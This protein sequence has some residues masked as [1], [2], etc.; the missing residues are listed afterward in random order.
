VDFEGVR[1]AAEHTP[2]CAVRRPLSDERPMVR[3]C[4]HR[5][6]ALGIGVNNTLFTI[7]KGVDFDAWFR[8]FRERLRR[9]W[10]VPVSVIDQKGHVVVTW[11]VHKDG[12]I[13][14]VVVGLQYLVS[15]IP[16]VTP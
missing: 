9:N 15:K 1:R 8:D 16:R 7:S 13:T 10:Y 2:G 5:R 12:A 6:L 4:G 11:Y 14:D 3:R